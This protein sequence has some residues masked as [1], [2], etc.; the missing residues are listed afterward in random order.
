MSSLGVR[1]RSRGRLHHGGD[2]L[3]ELLVGHARP[4]RRRAPV[5]WVLSISSTSS[6]KTF[7]P[8]VLMHTEPRPEQRDRPVGL[9]RR[10][11]ARHRVPHAVERDE[12]GRGLLR[13]LVVP[14]RAGG[15]GTATRPRSPEPGCDLAAVVGD[16]LRSG[17]ERE[18]RRLLLGTGGE[19]DWPSPM[20]SDDEN[21]STSSMP[22]LCRSRPCL[23]GLGPHHSRRGD[24]HQAGQVPAARVARRAR[25]GSASRTRRR[26]WSARRPSR[27]GS[28]RAARS[29]SR[30]RSSS[31]T[32]DPAGGQVD[33]GGEPA[34]AVHER[35]GRQPGHARAREGVDR[36]V[37]D[38]R[39][40]GPR[41]SGSARRRR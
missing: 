7:S 30:W 40:R 11:V 20:A 5:G 24:E 17:A 37:A 41:Q 32:S 34:G 6:G 35:A 29:T 22:G 12:R 10:V 4:R 19:T 25:A 36:G 15:P 23:D 26:R 28:C 13:V 33:V 2:G 27:A 8:P 1:R 21:E 14:D 16:D 18:V 9:D 38:R 31:R 3:A 39:P